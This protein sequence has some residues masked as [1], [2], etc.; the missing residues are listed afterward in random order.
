M[1]FN[2]CGIAIPSSGNIN[3]AILLI[4]DVIGCEMTLCRG[5]SCNLLNSENIGRR[6]LSSYRARY[7]VTEFSN[8]CT[9]ERSKAESFVEIGNETA[10]HRAL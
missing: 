4:I 2:K 1:N 6:T 3:R 7:D 5:L 9:E 8:C 10:S